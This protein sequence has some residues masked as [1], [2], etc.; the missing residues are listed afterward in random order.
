MPTLAADAE[1]RFAPSSVEVRSL[2]A[3]GGGNSI[4]AE[5]ARR[6]GRQDGAVLVDLGWISLGYDLA[7]G[8]SGLVFFGSDSWFGRKTASMRDAAAA[9][10]R[11][12][13]AV[14]RLARYAA[15]TPPRRNDE[16]RALAARCAL[17]LRACDGATIETLLRAA[18]DAGERDTLRSITYAPLVVAAAKHGTDGATLDPVV[19]GSVAEALRTGGESTLDNI[20]CVT[21]VA[22]T[23]D[24]DASR[25]KVVAVA[26]RASA[27]RHEGPYLVGMLTTSAAPI[28]FVTPFATQVVAESCATFRGVFVQRY[29]PREQSPDE[30]PSLVL[31]GAFCR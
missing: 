16:A 7:E 18:S 2:V 20:R 1:V 10:K 31:V 6:H 19:L 30:Q 14:D 27:I 24:P 17:D 4:R 26:G 28:Y 12:S 3:R 13:E 11:E 29:A 15:M 5:Y 8:A 25:G 22:A 21:S 23:R 9:A